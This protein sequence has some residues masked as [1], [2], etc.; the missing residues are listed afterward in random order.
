MEHEYKPGQYYFNHMKC[1]LF[2][3]LVLLFGCISFG[4][5]VSPIQYTQFWVRHS[6]GQFWVSQFWWHLTHSQEIIDHI[7]LREDITHCPIKQH[8]Q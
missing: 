6:A 5:V 4:D 3:D 8:Q 2:C 7:F 1:R